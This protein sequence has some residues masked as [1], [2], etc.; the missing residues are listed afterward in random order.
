MSE[1]HEHNC[2]ACAE[3]GHTCIPFFVHEN[4]MMH[5]DTDNERMHETMKSMSD[6]E[7][8][9]KRNMCITFIAIIII[10]VTAYT[11]RTNIWLSTVNRMN[12]T[13]VELANRILLSG[14]EVDNA[15]HQQP[16]H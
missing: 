2:S 16:D 6:N 10:F 5:K 9:S 7:V 11:V 1:R 3:K 13:I 15:V 12:D 4:A 14:A 8:K